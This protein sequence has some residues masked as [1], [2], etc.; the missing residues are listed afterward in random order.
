MRGVDRDRPST[1]DLHAGVLG[2]EL[3]G[4]LAEDLALVAPGPDV[5]RPAPSPFAIGSRPS[6]VKPPQAATTRANAAINTAVVVRIIGL[7]PWWSAARGAAAARADDHVG[8]GV[9]TRRARRPRAAR[10]AAAARSP[11][12]AHRP[13]DGGQG[14]CDEARELDV[15]PPGHGDLGPEAQA[16]VADGL[17]RAQ[18]DLVGGAHERGRPRS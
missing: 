2:L 12:R 8:G 9:G 10:A 16:P 5:D 6:A 18:R 17:V 15:V 7:P 4:E 1:F 13:P 3:L 14:R 11:S